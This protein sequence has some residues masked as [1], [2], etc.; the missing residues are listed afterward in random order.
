LQQRGLAS[1]CSAD[2]EN[3]EVG[4]LA[5]QFSGVHAVGSR[6]AP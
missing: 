2:N 5:S 6:R 3:A 4:I 1:I